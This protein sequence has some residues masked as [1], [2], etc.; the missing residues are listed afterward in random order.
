MYDFL[1]YCMTITLFWHHHLCF[2]VPAGLFIPSMAVGA[3]TGRM[4]GVGM[5]QLA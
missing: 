3:I 5:D 4:I 1:R 2:Q